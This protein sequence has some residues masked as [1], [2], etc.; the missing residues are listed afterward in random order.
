[1]SRQETATEQEVPFGVSYQ[2][3]IPVGLGEQ[4]EACFMLDSAAVGTIVTRE[5]W[6]LYQR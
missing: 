3:G 6:D 2:Y 1:M 5:A 4:V